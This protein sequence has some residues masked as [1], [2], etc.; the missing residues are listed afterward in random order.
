[1]VKSPSLGIRWSRSPRGSTVNGAGQLKDLTD[2][3]TAALSDLLQRDPLL[4]LALIEHLQ[5]HGTAAARISH[6]R[7]LGYFDEAGTLEAACWVG[8][9]IIPTPASH[10]AAAALGAY[11]ARSDSALGSIY[12]PAGAV[13]DI[14]AQFQH[15]GKTGSEV[16]PGQPVLS[17][18][19]GPAVPPAGVVR[20]GTLDE[21]DAVLPASAA[22]FAEEV[23]FAPHLGEHGSYR[24]KVASLLQRGH[25]LVHTDADGQVIFKADFGVVTDQ[26]VQVHGV[27]LRPSDRGKGLSAGYMADVVRHG[28]RLA[29]AVSL[30]VNDFNT[31]ACALYRRVGFTEAGRYA[32]VLF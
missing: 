14:Y 12:G 11:L 4:N 31:R 15:R 9:N 17:L 30:Y 6:T 18:T 2:A 1:M 29:P 23:G 22:M 13:L 16:R 8:S 20:V 7:M 25:T 5:R 24:R 3:D 28:L 26:A 10:R 32:T 27:W 21:L 19:E